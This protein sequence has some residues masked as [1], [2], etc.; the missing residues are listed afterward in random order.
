MPNWA[1]VGVLP[2]SIHVMVCCWPAVQEVVATGEV[3]YASQVSPRR[4]C[5]SIA[6]TYGDCGKGR[7]NKSKCEERS[8]E[9]G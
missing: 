5:P 6:R 9:H 1:R 7:G 3:I 8:G 2:S 4:S